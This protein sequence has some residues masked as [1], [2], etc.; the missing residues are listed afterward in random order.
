MSAMSLCMFV[1]HIIF[2]NLI[3]QEKCSFGI[4]VKMMTALWLLLLE[5]LKCTKKLSHR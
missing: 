1:N 2:I 4:L 3:L 5:T